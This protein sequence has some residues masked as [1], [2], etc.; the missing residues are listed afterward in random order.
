MSDHDAQN[1]EPCHNRGYI[2]VQADDVQ[3]DGSGSK[4][5]SRKADEQAMAWTQ[6]LRSSWI[7]GWTGEWLSLF[8]SLVAFVSTICALQY[9]DGSVVIAMPLGISVNTLTG[10]PGGKTR[11]NPSTTTQTL[12]KITILG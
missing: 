10:Y 7:N 9:L 2:A 1:L 3:I 6:R 8:L 12:K 11:K 4:E 5:Q